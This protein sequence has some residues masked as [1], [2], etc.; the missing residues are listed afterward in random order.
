[1]ASRDSTS[2]Y[3]C[4][5]QDNVSAQ[6]DFSLRRVEIYQFNMI[7]ENFEPLFR[8]FVSPNLLTLQLFDCQ[9]PFTRFPL[10]KRTAS[11]LDGTQ[12]HDLTK[13][14]LPSTMKRFYV[15]YEDVDNTMSMTN[16]ARVKHD[17]IKYSGENLPWQVTCSFDQK[18]KLLSFGF[19]FIWVS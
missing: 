14:Y 9:R 2:Y 11:F 8:L 3:G 10:P 12:W 17:F 1:M 6:H 4:Q 18:T 13:K 19:N 16:L 15:E 5:I 7:L